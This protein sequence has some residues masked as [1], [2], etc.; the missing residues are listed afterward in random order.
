VA[1]T[2]KG[3]VTIAAKQPLTLRYRALTIDGRF[4]DGM[5][6]KMAEAWRKS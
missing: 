4:P 1:I 3:P 6:D 2:A 5:L